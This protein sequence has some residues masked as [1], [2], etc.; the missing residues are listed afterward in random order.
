MLDRTRLVNKAKSYE[1]KMT[2][3]CRRIVSIP[4]FSC[5]EGDL[6]SML[7][8]EMEKN[9]FDRVKIDKMGNVIGVVGKG[10]T[11]IL[12]D[13][14][15]DT[16]GI[17]DRSAWKHDPFKGK[18]EKGR[19]YGRGACDQK[20]VMASMIYA[21]RMIKELDLAGDYQIWFVGSCQE[22]ECDGL[23]LIHLIEKEKMRPDFTVITEA[24]GLKIYRGHRGRMEIT[25]VTK[26]RSCHASAPDRGENAIYKMVPIVN[27][28]EDLGGRLADDPFLG[29]G[30]VAVTRIECQTPSNNAVPDECTI[31]LDRRLSVGETKEVAVGEI[32][33][34]P[35]IKKAKAKVEVLEY[36]AK[37]WKGLAV[38]Q[39]KYFPTWTIP[40]SHVLVQAGLEAGKIALG[41]APAIDKWVFSTNGVA[42]MGRYGIPT[43]GFGPS[44][45]V[46][47]HTVHECVAVDQLVK[48]SV[49]YAALGPALEARVR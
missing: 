44:D 34:L 11:K 6:A 36:Q 5:Q 47:A 4:S 23:P 15:I 2:T 19:I 1:S 8:S 43:I 30:T 12:V 39:E 31:Y 24:T 32:Q 20:G 27:E 48:A 37:T 40:E 22:E 49:F 16:V 17:G 29:K 7:A 21:G 33:K 14:H 46:L 35:A 18:F 3:L 10:K 38:S 28:I 26:G 45:E 25:V 13:A 41:R 42:T 9:K